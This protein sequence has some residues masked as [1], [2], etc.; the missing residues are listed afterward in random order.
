MTPK[1]ILTNPSFCPI[2]W[3]GLMYNQDG[4]VKNCIRSDE[5]LPIGNIQQDTIENIVLGTEN[6]SRQS[7]IIS[8]LPVASCHTCKELENNKKSFD[9]VSDRIFY[10]RELKDIPL[11]TYRVPNFDLQTID[12]RWTNLCNQACVYCSPE[13]SSKWASE[14][15]IQQNTPTESQRTKFKEYIFARARQLKHVY[16][17]G[18]EPLLM[19]ENLEL[20]DLLDPDV[21]LRVNTNLSKVN[22][23]IFD[24]VC[25]FKNVHWTVSIETIEDEYEYIRYGGSW[26]DFL[27]NLSVIQKLNHKISFNMLYFLLNYKSLFG[28]VD[29]LKDLGFHSNSFI[30]GA[31]LRPEYLNIRHLPKNQLQSVKE[32]LTDRINQKPGYLL[33]DSF[34]NLLSY[35]T[36][37]YEANLS[38]SFRKLDLLDK[39]R[40]LDSSKIFTE[41]YQLKEK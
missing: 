25:K 39:R 14:L 15:K 22:T 27:N 34:K 11:D 31:L 33:E 23:E 12:V 16:M 26:R 20:L 24:R 13:F 28:C 1:D 5:T 21:E 7:K 10:I 19:K 30:I 37:P 29:Y 18:G 8:K 2:P 35:V 36:M 17:A 32:I 3:T 4:K 40:Q 6:I 38:E 9:I 41:L